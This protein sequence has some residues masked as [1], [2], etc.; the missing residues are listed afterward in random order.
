MANAAN[1]MD[2]AIATP[3]RNKGGRPKWV[4]PPLDRVEAMAQRGL[5]RIQ[6]AAALG[7]GLNTLK[8]HMH[9][10]TEFAAA[11]ERGKAQGIVALAN[12]GYD[13]AIVGKDG[14]MIRFLLSTVGGF[15]ETSRL[16]VSGQDGEPIHIKA[17]VSAE[18]DVRV[19][20]KIQKLMERYAHV[21]REVLASAVDPRSLA[22]DASGTGDGVAQSDGPGEPLDP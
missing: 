6:I 10:S 17:D 5:S 1:N 14:S 16:E 11:V 21:A 2:T 12:A 18:I 7:I 3:A 20:P 19:D 15:R 8:R 13:L 22:R 4:P 9:D